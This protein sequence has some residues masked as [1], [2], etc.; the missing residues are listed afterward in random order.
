[1]VHDQVCTVIP[2]LSILLSVYSIFGYAKL[3]TSW[4]VRRKAFESTWK[5]RNACWAIKI[6]WVKLG[7]NVLVH[8]LSSM[9]GVM[10]SLLSFSE[11]ESSSHCEVVRF[12]PLFKV[13]AFFLAALA[14]VA[15]SKATCDLLD[16]ILPRKDLRT[17][18]EA[19]ASFLTTAFVFCAWFAMALPFP[20]W[21]N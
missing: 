1:M 15:G 20:D 5:L 4:T 2:R 6:L 9:N 16:V 8:R 17:F 18:R 10:A 7:R 19:T 11:P 3:N 21:G 13:D 14:W 12:L